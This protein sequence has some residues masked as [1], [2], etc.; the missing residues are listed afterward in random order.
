MA[1]ETKKK[2]GRFAKG[3]EGG[4]GRPKRITERAYLD[5]VIAVC[6]P[7]IWKD[8]VN[9]AVEDAKRGDVKAREWLSSYLIGKPE[10]RAPT[11]KEMAIDE[12]AG[13][14]ELKSTDIMMAS[15]EANIYK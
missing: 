15:L 7:D 8:V 9:K 1:T 11:L 3:H 10:Q 2:N 4:P 5:I 13:C 12:A 6:T 14:D